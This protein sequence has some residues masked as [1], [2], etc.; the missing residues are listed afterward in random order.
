MN[1]HSRY[2]DCRAELFCAHAALRGADREL[3]QTLMDAATTDACIELLD[4][5]GLREP[6]LAS[7]LDAIQ[8]HLERRAAGTYEI[9]AVVFS[10]VY[11][12][13]GQTERAKEMLAQWKGRKASST[14]WA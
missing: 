14:E 10:N 5:V 4:R 3:C 1:T 8:L 2:A 7:L 9:G 6:V 11:G 12:L 13:L